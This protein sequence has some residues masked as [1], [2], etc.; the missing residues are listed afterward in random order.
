MQVVS[1]DYL[2][3]SN[4]MRGLAHGTD[5]K[6]MIVLHETI[7]RDIPGWRDITSVEAYLR[8]VGYGI[9]GMTDAEGNRAWAHNMGNAVFYHAGGVN[10]RAIGIEQVSDIPL[11]SPVT[12]VRRKL[13]TLRTAEIHATAQLIACIINTGAYDIPLTFS[14]GLNPG[15]TSHYNVSQFHRESQGHTD[16]RPVHMGGWYPI[17]EVITLAKLYKKAGVHF[18]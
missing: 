4:Y 7:S 6:D 5:H 16:C 1:L 12:A 11:R 17:L 14:N 13:W 3:T 9:H 10:E 2:N 15:V 18:E 8:K